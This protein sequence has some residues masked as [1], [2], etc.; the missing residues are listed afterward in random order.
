MIYIFNHLHVVM[1]LLSST[2]LFVTSW[3]LVFLVPV[4]ADWWPSVGG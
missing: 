1:K 3:L 4:G 2:E